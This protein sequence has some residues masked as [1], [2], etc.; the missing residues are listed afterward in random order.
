[1]MRWTMKISSSH[2]LTKLLR[3]LNLRK[4]SITFTVS[5]LDETSDISKRVQFHISEIYLDCK[6]A[7]QERFLK[8]REDRPEPFSLSQWKNSNQLY[9]T[10]GWTPAVGPKVLMA[11]KWSGDEMFYLWATQFYIMLDK[12]VT[13]LKDR[14]ENKESSVIYDMPSIIDDKSVADQVV[15]RVVRYCVLQ[16]GCRSDV[17]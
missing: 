17:L 7:K 14:Y 13:N 8:S 6:G 3:V 12:I 9:L 15:Q 4:T 1:M 10:L 5:S 16:H 2:C 11:A